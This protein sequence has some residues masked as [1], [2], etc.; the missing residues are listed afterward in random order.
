MAGFLRQSTASQS[1]ALGPFL[2]DTDFKTPETGLTIANT[3]IKL[4]VNGGASANKNSGGGTHRVNGVYGVTFDATDSATVGEMEV[5]VLVSGALIVFD[6]FTI[7][8]E[9]VY[10]ALFAASAP[11]Y[12]QPTTAGRTLDVSAGGEAGIDW[13]N[14]G[15]PTTSVNLSSTNIDVDQVVASV[16]GAVGSVTGNVGGSTASVTGAVGSVTGAVGSVTGNV[17]GNVNG[18]VVG[19]VGSVTGLTA[20]NLDTTVSSRASAFNLG[21]AQADIDDIQT[22]L[23]ASL[24]SG[25]MN[26]DIQA[27]NNTPVTGDGSGTP[28]GP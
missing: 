19:S 23:P 1:R 25:R 10:D 9:A 7:L 13:A 15:S 4:V 18:N 8:E 6:K 17:G 20:S 27:I 14:I 28:W 26:S 22:R 12:L 5:S 3:D 11:G 21:L 24:V 2:D 16:S